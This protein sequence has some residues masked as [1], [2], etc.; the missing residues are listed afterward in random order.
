M[1][2]ISSSIRCPQSD[3]DAGLVW[4]H[5]PSKPIKEFFKDWEEKYTSLEW[6]P[7]QDKNGM[8]SGEIFSQKRV[9]TAS[10]DLAVSLL[11]FT[12]TY[13]RNVLTLLKEIQRRFIDYGWGSTDFR[14]EECRK[15]LS[16]WDKARGQ[17]IVAE[18]DRL[19]R[20]N[21]SPSPPDPLDEF[22]D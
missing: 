22:S 10:E 13:R 15:A 9:G 8:E 17:R 4:K 18:H 2:G 14:K 7:I 3:R 12:G 6:I 5:F 1:G 16:E 20:A 11:A 21:R 19:V